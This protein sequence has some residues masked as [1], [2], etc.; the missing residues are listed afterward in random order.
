[1]SFEPVHRLS[2]ADDLVASREQRVA[3]VRA[4]EARTACDDDPHARPMPEYVKPRRWSLPLSSRL[5][6]STIA[7]VTTSERILV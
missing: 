3:E 7:G 2:S 4:E 6:A 1:M 5:R